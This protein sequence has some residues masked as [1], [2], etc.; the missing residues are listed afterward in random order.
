M[1]SDLKEAVLDYL[2]FSY[3]F[4]GVD[5]DENSFEVFEEV[6]SGDLE[7]NEAIST[8]IDEA[9]LNVE[10]DSSYD[11]MGRYPESRCH[12]NYFN[13]REREE[14][15]RID[16]FLSSVRTCE[17]ILKPLE[18][19]LTFEYLQAIHHMLFSDIYPS[20]G[21][22]RRKEENRRTEFCRP[23]FIEKQSED[24]FNKLRAMKYLRDLEDVDEF[25]NEVAYFMGEMEAL[26]P[27]NDGNGRATRLFFNTLAW[28]AGY[29]II[30][31]AVDPDRLLEANIAAIDGDYQALVDV[32]EEI[33][34]PLRIED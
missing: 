20:A 18:M 3:E 9:G 11:E 25:V 5:A 23:E 17:L 30:Y 15:K 13:I 8:F 32:L 7:A 26:H 16:M 21:M 19:G 31:H 6:L 27:F 34:I 1:K 24:I 14:L 28:K 29:D 4:E 22:I 33:V 12:V 10:Y 2:R